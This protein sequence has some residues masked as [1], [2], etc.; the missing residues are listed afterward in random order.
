MLEGAHI[1][2]KADYKKSNKQDPELN[3]ATKNSSRIWS[4]ASAYAA[5]TS[6]KDDGKLSAAVYLSGEGVKVHP[7]KLATRDFQ[8][9]LLKRILYFR[10]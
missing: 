6:T 4:V 9:S 10:S 2:E 7:K 8:Y 3:W 5:G 1:V